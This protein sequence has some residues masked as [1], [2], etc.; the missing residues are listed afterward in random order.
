M[1]LYNRRAIR[2]DGPFLYLLFGLA[3]GY[4]H[5]VFFITEVSPPFQNNG[6]HEYNGFPPFYG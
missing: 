2:E 5:L 1:F 4:V 3:Y 6:F